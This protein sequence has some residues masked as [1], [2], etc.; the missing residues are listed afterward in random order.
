[1]CSMIKS[2]KNYNA[3]RRYKNE[4]EEDTV[5]SLADH[6]LVVIIRCMNNEE[7][8]EEISRK[9]KERFKVVEFIPEED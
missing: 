6:S 1:M 8:Y 7:E 9:V 5:P 4:S 2:I 3:K